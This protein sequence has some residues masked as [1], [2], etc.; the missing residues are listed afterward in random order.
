MSAST[1]ILLVVA[2][3]AMVALV[4]IAVLLLAAINAELE[5][6]RRELVE[7]GDR[8][9]AVLGIASSEARASRAER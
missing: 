7:A 9:R 2:G 6:I 8:E 1:I 5:R 3:V 4:A